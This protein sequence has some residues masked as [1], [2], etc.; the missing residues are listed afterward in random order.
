[1]KKHLYAVIVFL[2][3]LL[4]AFTLQCFA[5]RKSTTKPATTTRLRTDVNSND[6][7]PPGTKTG[8][9]TPF[10]ATEYEKV[11]VYV[12]VTDAVSS[13]DNITTC[14]ITPLIWNQT[15]YE[16]TPDTPNGW[17][18]DTP[19]Q[20]TRHA[21]DIQMAVDSISGSGYVNI[22]VQGSNSLELEH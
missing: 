7:V 2:L 12:K 20:E 6:C 4:F 9:G 1:M 11:R 15:L 14:T 18:P 19:N 22:F 17:I 3:A 8:Y 5:Q 21:E 10:D 13:P 16:W